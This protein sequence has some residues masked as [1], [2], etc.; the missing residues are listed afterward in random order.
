ML[1]LTVSNEGFGLI[2]TP[3]THLSIM[4]F[5]YPIEQHLSYDLALPWAHTLEVEGGGVEP[6][7][8]FAKCY[9]KVHEIEN[10]SDP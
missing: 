9:K 6:T 7:Y 5:Q 3:F 2:Y 1:S 10:I 4:S 8:D